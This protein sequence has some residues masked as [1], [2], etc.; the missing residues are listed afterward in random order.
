MDCGGLAAPAIHDYN[1]LPLLPDE[2]PFDDYPDWTTS[3]D[4]D[5]DS[6]YGDD[7]DDGTEI[8]VDFEG[9][10]WS[11]KKKTMHTKGGPAANGGLPN[12]RTGDYDKLYWNCS[13]V[14]KGSDLP[15]CAMGG[16]LSC[17]WR[18]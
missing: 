10:T 15:T 2:H 9:H 3:S 13:T 1:D 5:T 14:G 18:V 8:D 7:A 4:E 11:V 12:Y 17:P 16:C 6:D